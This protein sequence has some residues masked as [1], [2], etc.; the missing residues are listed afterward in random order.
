MQGHKYLSSALLAVLIFGS[1][2]ALADS[3]T[4]FYFPT[5]LGCAVFNNIDVEGL[6]LFKGTGMRMDFYDEV[7]YDALIDVQEDGKY[8]CVITNGAVSDDDVGIIMTYLNNYSARW[9]AM[10]WGGPYDSEKKGVTSEPNLVTVPKTNDTEILEGVVVRGTSLNFTE[11]FFDYIPNGVP[12]M[13]PFATLAS[14]ANATIAFADTTNNIM[15]VTALCE[16]TSLGGITL[17]HIALQYVTENVFMGARKVAISPQVDDFFLSS[18]HLV[19]RD[20][21]SYHLTLQDEYNNK[22]GDSIKFALGINGIA[23]KYNG[24]TNNYEFGPYFDMYAMDVDA[25]SMPSDNK[26]KYTN[27]WPDKWYMN[28]TFYGSW[29]DSFDLAQ[30]ALTEEWR[31]GFLWHSHTFTH[32]NMA[33]LSVADAKIE[34]GYSIDMATHL[35][36]FSESETWS[37]KGFISGTYSGMQNGA[38]WKAMDE[39]GMTN[40]LSNNDYGPHNYTFET[41]ANFLPYITTDGIVVIQAEPGK[42]FEWG[43]KTTS[44]SETK[45]KLNQWTSWYT[46]GLCFNSKDDYSCAQCVTGGCQCSGTSG[47]VCVECGVG[48]CEAEPVCTNPAI[49]TTVTTTASSMTTNT[50]I[51]T[52]TSV[53][54]SDP[55]SNT[56]TGTATST[57]TGSHTTTSMTTH[58]SSKTTTSPSAQGSGTTDPSSGGSGSEVAILTGSIVGGVAVV[59]LL[60]FGVLFYKR[61]RR[62]DDPVSDSASV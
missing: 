30:G 24:L 25:Y 59:T 5:G 19:P 56:S 26:N 14:D 40:S 35:L 23:T 10:N 38:V 13:V 15:Y 29:F 4:K 41:A 33:E 46:G 45:C 16:N 61:S 58:A 44:G 42:T 62:G 2:V 60:T 20:N 6:A 11:L 43:K 18:D 17:Q 54:T 51:S 28:E 22:T 32:P 50:T 39:L 55:S 8:N 34:L 47:Q 52:N 37:S 36:G 1:A 31:D 21:V 7:S 9:V 3:S 49:P 27:P 53:P 57:G 12:N 48:N